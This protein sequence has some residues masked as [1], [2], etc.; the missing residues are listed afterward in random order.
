MLYSFVYNRVF[1]PVLV[2]NIYSASLS[3][4]NQSLGFP[5]NYHLIF[6]IFGL[7]QIVIMIM[8]AFLPP[9]INKQ[10][11]AHEDLQT[12]SESL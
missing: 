5:V 4:A 3:E 12:S 10:K 11:I 8:T 6:I 9:S 2:G 7:I 1:S